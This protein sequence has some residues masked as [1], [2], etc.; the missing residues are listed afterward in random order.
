[1][2]WPIFSGRI[3][4][5]DLY[6]VIIGT[7]DRAVSGTLQRPFKAQP[8]TIIGDAAHHVET[9]RRARDKDWLRRV[10]IIAWQRLDEFVRIVTHG[11]AIISR[12]VA[13]VKPER[14]NGSLLG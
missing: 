8:A 10:E 2:C 12:R 1:M 4:T 5:E 6:S 11:K 7:L 13:R 3:G 9:A 14:W